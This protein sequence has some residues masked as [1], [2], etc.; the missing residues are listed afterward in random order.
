MFI[1]AVNSTKHSS[2]TH[3]MFLFNTYDIANKRKLNGAQLELS[4]GV[5]YP[6]ERMETDKEVART[7]RTLKRH[8]RQSNNFLTTNLNSSTYCLVT[9]MLLRI[10]MHLFFM[11]RNYLVMLFVEKHYSELKQ[12]A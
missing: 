6:K 4:Y 1:W 2:H 10:C 9:V 7:Y 8:S 5:F 3:N 12:F 11:K